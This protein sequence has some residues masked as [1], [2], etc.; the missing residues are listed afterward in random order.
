MCYRGYRKN[1]EYFYEMDLKYYFVIVFVQK[2][3]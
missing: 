1:I 3:E 2:G